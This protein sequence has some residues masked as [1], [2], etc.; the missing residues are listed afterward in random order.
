MKGKIAALG[1]V[2][3]ALLALSVSPASS[4]GVNATADAGV[5]AKD[6]GEQFVKLGRNVGCWYRADEPDHLTVGS[7]KL[8]GTVQI[9]RCTPRPPDKCHVTAAIANPIYNVEHKD[10]GWKSC[11]KKTLKIAYTCQDM[12]TKKQY[13]T[14]GSIA[15]VYKGHA[16][17]HVFHSKKVTQFCA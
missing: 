12:V 13:M 17:S 1:V 11:K 15:M 8:W 4:A 3:P 9:T 14:V 6:S 2:V 7:R 5:T 10:D 16:Q